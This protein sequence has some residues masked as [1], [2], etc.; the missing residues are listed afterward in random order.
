ME[1]NDTKI[2]CEHIFNN[3]KKSF[4]YNELSNSKREGH[5]SNYVFKFK[6]NFDLKECEEYKN[7]PKEIVDIKQTH[8]PNKYLGYNQSYYMHLTNGN[9]NIKYHN[10]NS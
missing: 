7:I 2:L 10:F 4:E 3:L 1:I 6:K 9:L 5:F 8:E